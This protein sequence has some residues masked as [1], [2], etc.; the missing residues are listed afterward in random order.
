M[1][2][3][4]SSKVKV[5]YNRIAQNYAQASRDP[6]FDPIYQTWYQHLPKAAKI[7]DL[8]GGVG[9]DALLF[10]Q[11]G[12]QVDLVDLSEE[13][14][15]IAQKTAPKATIIV[16]DMLDFKIKQKYYDGIW[17]SGSLLHLT[18]SEMKTMLQRI[19][20]GLKPNGIFYCSLRTQ[21]QP[22]EEN[23]QSP[24]EFYSKQQITELLTQHQ[25][26]LLQLK[27]IDSDSK[28]WICIFTQAEKSAK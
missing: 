18:K 8:G 27:T 28:T 10:T 9:H 4:Y 1:P 26:N 2:S 14:V 22:K 12:Y 21:S 7:L 19:H 6:A 17:A 20:R 24:K 16:S 5:R 23:T 15:S 13:M 11:R 25:F 3:K